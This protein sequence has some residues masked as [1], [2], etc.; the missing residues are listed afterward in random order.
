M[1]YDI[2]YFKY[3]PKYV[4]CFPW[5]IGDIMIWWNTKKKVLS[6]VRVSKGFENKFR[7]G[8]Y[9]KFLLRQS[10][11]FRKSNKYCGFS[12]QIFPIWK[13]LLPRPRFWAF[14]GSGESVF[15]YRYFCGGKCRI[16][17]E[18]FL[19]KGANH[20]KILYRPRSEIYSQTSYLPELSKEPFSS[21]SI[22]S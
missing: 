4:S 12:G 16:L 5:K 18:I 10:H 1:R 11:L 9:T 20:E 6:K 22:I 19:K 13:K 8:V 21:C 15:L 3:G 17:P 7:F 14:P 2:R